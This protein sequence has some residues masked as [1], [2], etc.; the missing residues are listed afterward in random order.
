MAAHVR[1]A[2]GARSGA[3]LI[4]KLGGAT[5]EADELLLWLELLREECGVASGLTVPLESQA[6][7][8]IAIFITMMRKT[9]GK[10]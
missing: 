3:E 1:E 10:N 8:L 5:Q 9:A 2:S 4:S 6:S 7:E